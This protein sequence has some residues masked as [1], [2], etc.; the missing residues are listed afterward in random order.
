[1]EEIFIL[2]ARGATASLAQ[3]HLAGLAQAARVQQQ[4]AATV[5]AFHP[6]GELT[7]QRGDAGNA[8]AGGLP[9]RQFRASTGRNALGG[10][11]HALDHQHHQRHR[12]HHDE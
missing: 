11:P 5:R 9:Q 8:A 2:A 3:P 7:F 10:S 4:H 6:N 1:M 12:G